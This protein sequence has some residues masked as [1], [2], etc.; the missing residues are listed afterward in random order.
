MMSTLSTISTSILT[1]LEDEVGSNEWWTATE[2]KQ[3]INDAYRSIGLSLP[4]FF[5]SRDGTT[6]TVVDQIAYSLPTIA[7]IENIIKIISVD[8]DDKMLD[9]VTPDYLNKTWYKWRDEGSGTPVYYYQEY[10]E[11][12]QKISL[13]PKPSTADKVI[14][15]DCWVIPDELADGGEPLEPLKNGLILKE[16]TLSMAL[17]KAGGGR[18]LDRSDYYWSQFVTMMGALTGTQN[19]KKARGLHGIGEAPTITGL[20]L[21]DHYPAYYFD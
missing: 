5:R 2:I 14:G 18:D 4:G 9:P 12:L 16:A 21:G 1:K 7:G 10:G 20:R 15:I 17:A 13:F 11:E 19:P 8:Y 3:W 6:V